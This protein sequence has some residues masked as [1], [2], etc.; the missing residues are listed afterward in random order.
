ML[1]TVY[2]RPETLISCGGK[3]KIMV[4]YLKGSLACCREALMLF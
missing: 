1:G 3:K 2:L 4:G